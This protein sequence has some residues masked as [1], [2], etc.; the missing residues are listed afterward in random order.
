MTDNLHRSDLV[1]FAYILVLVGIAIWLG[2]WAYSDF[3]GRGWVPHDTMTTVYSPDWQYG[4]YKTC[5]TL[6]GY[7]NTRAENI[8]CDGGVPSGRLEDG[9]A[10]MVRFWGKTYDEAKPFENV[11]YWKCRR[12]DGD[13]PSITCEQAA[14]PRETNP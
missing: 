12:N 8:L 9:K 3:D 10:F 1:K 13:D 2:F 5:T 11:S 6:N 7:K 4:E 14:E